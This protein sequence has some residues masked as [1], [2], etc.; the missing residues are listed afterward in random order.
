MNFIKE[1]HPDCKKTT[2]STP[3]ICIDSYNAHKVNESFVSSLKE[4]DMSYITYCNII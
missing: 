2:L 4:S 1:K 3:I